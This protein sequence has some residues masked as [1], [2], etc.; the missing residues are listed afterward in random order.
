MM[1]VSVLYT[2]SRKV[3]YGTVYPCVSYQ[4]EVDYTVEIRAGDG[5]GESVLVDVQQ[6]VSIARWNRGERSGGFTFVTIREG[7]RGVARRRGGGF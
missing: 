6:G 5:T 1:D 2:A 4:S 7:K 3:V